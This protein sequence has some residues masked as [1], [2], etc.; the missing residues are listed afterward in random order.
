[1]H[2]AMTPSEK[3]LFESFLRCSKRYVEFGAGG[4]TCFAA[5]LV[6]G[7]VT[8]TDS[9]KEWLERV[10][11]ECL[12]QDM[13]VAPTLVHVDI[14]ETGRWGYPA[15]GAKKEH[16]PGYHTAIWSTPGADQA[17]LYLVDGRFRVACFM[18]VALR[19]QPGALVAI[20]DFA[21][22][23]GYHV[24][25]EVAREIATSESLSV[26]VRRPD[27]DPRRAAAILDEHAFNPR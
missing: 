5:S 24:V 17:D 23:P 10:R 12:A 22:R 21:G 8:S 19:A 11:V 18:Q 9:S 25:R 20:H 7:A 16:W 27:F 13:P 14:G 6:S 3:G 4:S 15:D 2:V 26:F 1:M